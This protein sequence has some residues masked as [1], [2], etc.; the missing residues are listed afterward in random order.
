MYVGCFDRDRSLTGYGINESLYLLPPTM[1]AGSLGCIHEGLTYFYPRDCD[2][3]L[4]DR[5]SEFRFY[6]KA[7]D[8]A[9]ISIRWSNF[10]YEQTESEEKIWFH[11]KQG[12]TTIR[13][14]L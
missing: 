4:S 2:R 12:T 13:V 10:D 14:P 1:K 6:Q 8:N 7:G 11:N 3:S 9:R 5:C